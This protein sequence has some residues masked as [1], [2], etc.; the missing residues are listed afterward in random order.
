MKMKYL[1]FSSVLMIFPAA[2]F[3]A[4]CAGPAP[5]DYVPPPSLSLLGR[6]RIAFAMSVVRLRIS[7]LADSLQRVA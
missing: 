5:C 1:F 3:S 6:T 2:S 7:G 4:T